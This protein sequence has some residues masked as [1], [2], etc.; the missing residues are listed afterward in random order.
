ML[1]LRV[2]DAVRQVPVTNPVELE[3]RSA[4]GTGD[5]DRVGGEIEKP[6]RERV[7]PGL[8]RLRMPKAGPKQRIIAVRY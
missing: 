4:G 2:G 6:R 1:R 3:R 5:L 8:Q 7:V